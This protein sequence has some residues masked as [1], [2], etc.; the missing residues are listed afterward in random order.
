[1][2]G[3]SNPK[4]YS[5]RIFGRFILFGY[6]LKGYLDVKIP[7]TIQMAYLDV[8]LPLEI[9]L[10]GYLDVHQCLFLMYLQINEQ[11]EIDCHLLLNKVNKHDLN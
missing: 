11:L 2:F 6:F 8:L 1:M 9:F 5:N 7:K 3:R 10:K 4:T